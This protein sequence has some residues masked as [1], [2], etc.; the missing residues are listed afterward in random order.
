MANAIALDPAVV[1]ERL[2][3]AGL[4]GPREKAGFAGQRGRV[5]VVER[6]TNGS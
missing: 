6:Y 1:P 5:M 4:V 2:K 3:E